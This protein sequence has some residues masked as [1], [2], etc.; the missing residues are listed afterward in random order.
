MSAKRL[1]PS[2]LTY[3]DFEQPI[4]GLEKRIEALQSSHDE[5]D[6]LDISKELDL[7]QKKNNKLLQDTYQNLTAW[8]ISQ[9]AR[10]PQRPYTMDYINALFTD[11]QELHGDRAFSDDPAIVGGT[12]RF[13]G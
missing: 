8:Q 6:S 2:K 10:H 9:V 4:A 7:L 3:L 11:F 13:K 12:A 5:H 1:T